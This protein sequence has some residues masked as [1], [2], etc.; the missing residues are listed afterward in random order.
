MAASLAQTSM[1]RGGRICLATRDPVLFSAYQ[2]A[3]HRGPVLAACHQGQRHL[4][5]GG[6]ANVSPSRAMPDGPITLSM[7][8]WGCTRACGGPPLHA[9]MTGSR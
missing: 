5:P 6:E 7:R 3:P 1:P 8:A 4:S 9:T 2:E